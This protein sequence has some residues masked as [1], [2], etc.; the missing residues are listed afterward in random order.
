MYPTIPHTH[1]PFL[2]GTNQREVTD[3][4]L[5]PTLPLD[6]TLPTA[7]VS[8]VRQA[9]H[10]GGAPSGVSFLTNTQVCGGSTCEGEVT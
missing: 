7:M 3:L 6:V 8:T 5:H 10:L 4:V 2:M 9:T 1:A